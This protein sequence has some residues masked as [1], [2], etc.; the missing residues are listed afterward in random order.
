[1]SRHDLDQAAADFADALALWRGEP[2]PDLGESDFAIAERVRLDGLRLDVLSERIAVDL[3]LGRSAALVPELESLSNSY[4]LRE[5][6][7]RQLVMALAA[8][9]RTPEALAA[10]ERYRSRLADELG[11]DP[12]ADLQQLHLQLLRGQDRD[13]DDGPGRRHNLRA[14]VSSFLGRDDETRQLAEQLELGRLVTVVGPGG[15]GKTRLAGVA[16]AQWNERSDDGV[17]LVELAPVTDEANIAQAILES[18]G[19]RTSQM[20]ER[21][22]DLHR[23]ASD[24]RLHELLADSRCLLVIDNCEH[25]ING[26][27]ELVDLL[28]ARCPGVRVLATSREPLGIAGESLC[29]LSPLSLPADDIGLDLAVTYPAIELF[30]DRA[31]SVQPTFALTGDNLDPVVE[32][33]RRLDGLPLAIELAAAR[34]RVLPLPE[35]A[36]RLSDRF[37]LLSGGSRAALPRHRTLRAV[38]EWSWELLTDAERTLAARLSVFPAGVTL[39]S[40]RSVCLDSAVLIDQLSDVLD[41]LVDKS[42]LQL[43]EVPGEPDALRYRMLE[44]L[45]E[46]GIEQLADNGELAAVRLAHGR[47]FADLVAEADRRIRTAEQVPW[48][49]LLA[50]ERGNI[51]SALRYLAESGDSNDALNMAV[52]LS[53]YWTMIDAHGEAATWLE[54]VLRAPGD[55]DDP[56]RVIAQAMHAI[57]SLATTFGEGA[58]EDIEQGVDHL[59]VMR[60]RLDRIRKR[61][62][63]LAQLDAHQQALILLLRPLMAMFGGD[64]DQVEGLL[65]EAIAAD[66]EWVSGAAYMFRA[67][68]NENN[69]DVEGMRADATSALAIFRRLGDRWGLASTMTHLAQLHAYDGQ[70]DEAI[71]L[72]QQAATNLAAYGAVADETLTHL[73]LSDLYLQRG[74]VATAIAEA[75]RSRAGQMPLGSRPRQLLADSAL[76]GIAVHLDDRPEMHRLHDSLAAELLTYNPAPANGHVRAGALI[77]LSHLQLALGDIEAAGQSA[78]LA[79]PASLATRDMPIVASNAVATAMYAAAIGQYPAGAEILG[80]AARLRG[81]EHRT[82]TT[83]S[84]IIS[85]LQ[86]ELGPEFE[87]AYERGRTLDRETAIKRIDPATLSCSG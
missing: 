85:L 14:P 67:N 60:Q 57:N 15:A 40:A 51:N 24:E 81:S 78:T 66:D 87:A 22:I 19:V 53:W 86:G 65:G 10:Y 41:S 35:I 47:Y 43:A 34:L 76:A 37:R 63:S 2:L 28:L 62:D 6:F 42:L 33:V 5:G 79:Y 23:L 12:S 9:G 80:A 64:E 8:S 56:I 30:V 52:A 68:L 29:L 71:A 61:A 36:A 16:G 26:V 4:V 55:P 70:I 45:R 38:V 69:G 3:G 21:G 25:L 39:A 44:T 84:R 77:A 17:W 1:Q 59:G 32:I 18:L 13:G 48:L 20:L 31:R 83:V 11:V 46:Y 72:Y 58:P 82:A 27:A 73:S 54:L 7:A 75:E 49:L 50:T 74:D